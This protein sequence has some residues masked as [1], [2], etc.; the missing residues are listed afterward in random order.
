MAVFM[1]QILEQHI[2]M[3]LPSLKSELNSEMTAVV[4]ELQTYGQVAEANVSCIVML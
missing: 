2:R 3:V 4:K 1:Y